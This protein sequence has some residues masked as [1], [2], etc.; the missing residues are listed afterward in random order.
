MA[1][2]NWRCSDLHNDE[3]WWGGWT[4]AGSGRGESL[5]DIVA[6]GLIKV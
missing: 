4:A 5:S 1:S 3:L 6:D 2:H